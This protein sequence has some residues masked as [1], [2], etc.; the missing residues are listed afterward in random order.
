MDVKYLGQ[1][2]LDIGKEWCL[3][4]YELG[5]SDS[6]LDHL[7][8]AFPY[9][10]PQCVAS[11]LVKWHETA[12][13]HHINPLPLLIR[14]FT[15][16]DRYDLVQKLNCEFDEPDDG[17]LFNN[18]NEKLSVFNAEVKKIR[19]GQAQGDMQMFL[20]Q[21][22]RFL[23]FQVK[24]KKL[25]V[26][27][28]AARV[29]LEL[30]STKGTLTLMGNPGD[31]KSTIAVN[32]LTRLRN[33]GATIIVLSDPALIERIYDDDK[34]IVYFVDDAFGTPT[35]NSRLLETWTRLHDKIESLVK[36]DKCKLLITTR[37]HVYMKCQ[38]LLHKCP[39]YKENLIDLSGEE[40]RLNMIEKNRI[41][42][43]YC[44]DHGLFPAQLSFTKGSAYVPGFPL[45][46]KMF[47]NDKRMQEL[48]VYFD[49][50]L[51]V[52]YNQLQML[53]TTDGHS[54]CGLVLVMMFDG[55]LPRAVFDQFTPC[56]D[57]DR[58]KIQ[59]IMRVYGIQAC[60]DGKV[61]TCLDEMIGV[62]VEEVEED[63]RFIHDAIFDT[64]CLIFGTRYPNEIIRV[65]SS[66]FIE[67]RIRTENIP[68]ANNHFLDD[69]I[70]LK[71]SKYHVLA[72]RWI[73]DASRGII[74]A[75][76]VNPSIRDVDMQSALVDRIR[77]L[78]PKASMELLTNAEEA[79]TSSK[80]QFKETVLFL[81]CKKG[82]VS[83]VQV[84]LEKQ[85]LLKADNVVNASVLTI[86]DSCIME[87]VDRIHL[88]VV[89]ALLDHGAR[90]NFACG[91]MS[92]RC[93]QVACKKGSLDMVKLLMRYGADVNLEDHNGKQAVH[94]ASEF[95]RLE[96]LK[97]LHN[98]NASL[99]AKDRTDRQ[100]IHYAGIAGSLECVQFLQQEGTHLN[101]PDRMD[102]NVLHYASTAHCPA[103]IRYLVSNGADINSIDSMGASPL[104]LACKANFAEN[105]EILL[106]NGSDPNQ[107]DASMRLPLHSACKFGGPEQ[108][109]RD[110]FRCVQLLLNVVSDVNAVDS[111]GKTA[112]HYA[113]T[114]ARDRRFD[115]V[116]LLL[117][118]GADPSIMDDYER[119]PIFYACESGNLKCVQTLVNH[120]IDVNHRGPQG[121][122]PIHYACGRGNIDVVKMLVEKGA[123]TNS[124]DSKGKQPLH[125][126][127][128]HGNNDCLSY[129]L[130]CGVDVNCVDKQGC[131]P[132]HYACK[133]CRPNAVR[134]LIKHGA[135]P[136]EKDNDDRMPDDLVPK[137]SS[138]K[139]QMKRFLRGHSLDTI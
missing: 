18:Q 59:T 57:Q 14:S 105:I 100:A 38:S 42:A 49:Q 86:P 119:Q 125:Y 4:A 77:K 72:A 103:L 111:F 74:R 63:F 6:Q 43:S 120:G 44:Q 118:K 104:H 80:N 115:C 102:K 85:K 106:S 56:C 50:T 20:D 11:M 62:Y 109:G 73:A 92:Y 129:L 139:S 95:G 135:S 61:E 107:V 124:V 67:K 30:L 101:V 68:G 15:G 99:S 79:N 24:D 87:A 127:S 22:E 94:Y 91:S 31:G 51:S 48:D 52:L 1:L 88:N 64:V 65:A 98:N 19:F 110:S 66:N 81:A 70:V 133:W 83:L 47:G 2:S 112:L 9:N 97:E 34:Q 25:F 93:L 96:I 23:E 10:T 40:Y 131:R 3:L 32:L 37:K 39:S 8:A 82:F 28:R 12:L 58:T 123:S 108:D 121:K 55:R 137:W 132:L 36:L 134:L 90:V 54:F 78:A 35:V 69:V 117:S 84:L 126:A 138:R 53:A 45:L 113:C 13:K 89:N 46:C 76:F 26:N 71:K 60:D 130:E 5:F 7:R 21:S 33:E 17:S 114:W 136:E 116:T 16:V 128:Q 27:T 122:Q 41:V 29:A 75:M